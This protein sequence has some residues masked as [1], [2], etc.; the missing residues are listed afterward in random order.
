MFK[1][2]LDA[3][4]GQNTAGKR[5]PKALD[6]NQTREWTLNDRVSRYIAQAAALYENVQLL[7][8]DDVT[9][10]KN[11]SLGARCSAA[12]SWE[13]DVYISNHHNAGIRL[14]KGGGIVAYCYQAGTQAAACRDA[15]YQACISAGGLRGNRANPTPE[16]GFYVLKHTK[17]P[18]VLMEYGFMD[19]TTDAPVILTEDYAKRMGYA[20]MEAV[21]K[22]YGLKKRTQTNS[23]EVCSVEVKVLKKGAKGDAVKAMQLLLIGY[24][25]SCGGTGADGD[26]GANTDKALR[27]LQKARGLSVDG[28]CG[29]KTWGALLGVCA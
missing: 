10:K 27:A 21:A 19:S 8:V 11:I 18:A 15:I 16:K 26:F 25:Y 24:G 2:A 17:A 23:K 9:G 14:G 5:I 22:V 12:N 20:V 29:E 4:H 7:R 1:I 6:P 3:G 28:V 13:A